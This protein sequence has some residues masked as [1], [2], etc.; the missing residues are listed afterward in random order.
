MVV[1]EYLVLRYLCFSSGAFSCPCPSL[2]HSE[3]LQLGG[4]AI[5]GKITS[6]IKWKPIAVYRT[7]TG[8][9]S[10][11]YFCVKVVYRHVEIFTIKPLPE[12]LSTFSLMVSKL[13][14]P[15]H[16]LGKVVLK[17]DNRNLKVGFLKM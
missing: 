13:K 7:D 3:L 15:K 11:L 16:R 8:K 12:F 17:S 10:I 14:Y 1:G 2:R 5:V 6:T 9:K 4:T